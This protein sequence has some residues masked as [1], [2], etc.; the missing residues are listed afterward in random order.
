M[1]KVKLT[2]NKM[3][4]E[5]VLNGNT[6]KDV[7]K[8][9]GLAPSHV[10]EITCN[11]IY[12]VY[13]EK[14]PVLYEDISRYARLINLKKSRE[15]ATKLIPLIREIDREDFAYRKRPG[16]RSMYRVENLVVE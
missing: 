1:V 14:P 12:R 13:R 2:R 4:A 9:F 6:L 5:L 8:V 11:L 15:K 3:I 7:G 16:K 10:R